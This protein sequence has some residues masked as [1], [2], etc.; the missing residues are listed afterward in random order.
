[1]GGKVHK[2]TQKWVGN[3][4]GYPYRK[5]IYDEKDSFFDISSCNNS[6]LLVRLFG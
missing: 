5:G 6:S 1:M 2:N 4:V 3:R